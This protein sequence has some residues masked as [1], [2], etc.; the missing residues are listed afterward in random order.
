MTSNLPYI[1]HWSQMI[2]YWKASFGIPIILWERHQ[3]TSPTWGYC[4]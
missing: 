1:G 3:E 4:L 2:E